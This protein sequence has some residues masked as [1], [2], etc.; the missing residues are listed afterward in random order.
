MAINTVQ[1]VINGQTHNLTYDAGSG[2]YKATITAPDKS[3]FNQAGGYYGVTVIATDDGGNRV[4]VNDT[5]GTFGEDLKLVVT[6]SNAPVITVN[7]LTEGAHIQSNTPTIE[8]TV[9]DDDSGVDESTISITVN[10]EA[11]VTTGFTKTPTAGGYTCSYTV[12][13]ALSDGANVIKLDA[14]DND[15]NPAVQKT[16]NFVVDTVSPE[17]V[18]NAPADNITVA[19][20]ELTISGTTSD[21]TSEVTLTVEV[22]NSGPQEVPIVGG[23]FSTTVQLIGGVNTIEIVATDSAGKTTT[24]TR[25]VTVDSVPTIN[26][27]TITPNPVEAGGTITITVSVTD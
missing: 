18:I 17:L 19:D 6:E 27:I 14:S 15:G 8:W 11:P 24:I 25:T 9:T 26:S 23:S 3:S 16:I 2:T 20:T 10:S 1:V 5:H 7:N 13:V 22:N 4:E 12:P 21:L